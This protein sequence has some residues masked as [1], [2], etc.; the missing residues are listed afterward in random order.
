MKI[1]FGEILTI[2]EGEFLEDNYHFL[3][4]VITFDP[5]FLGPYHLRLAS[6][7]ISIYQNILGM[8]QSFGAFL[9]M[10]NFLKAPETPPQLDT[11]FACPARV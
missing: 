11:Y 6:E 5:Q 3:V 10:P 9:A 1:Y 7:T 2:I 4:N 8:G